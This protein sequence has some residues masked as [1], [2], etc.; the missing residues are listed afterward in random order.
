MKKILTLNEIL[1]LVN[2]KKIV[3]A[4]NSIIF[5]NKI[6]PSE[7]LRLDY[8]LL[9][10]LFNNALEPDNRG[11]LNTHILN[12]HIITSLFLY[13][14]TRSLLLNY[15][16][17]FLNTR[18]LNKK[19]KLLP[20]TVSTVVVRESFTS[21]YS[22][23]FAELELTEEFKQK[24]LIIINNEIKIKDESKQIRVLIFNTSDQPILVSNDQKLFTTR[25]F[26]K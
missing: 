5:K 13:S 8:K 3:L 24:G 25:L 20:N 4:Y 18:L 16:I 26:W 22:N 15:I 12:L 1:E 6:D 10:E 19:V 23:L 2:A 17:S 7:I 11:A 21:E 9:N 14:F